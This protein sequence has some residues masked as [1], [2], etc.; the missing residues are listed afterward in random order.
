M[1]LH[2]RIIG[3]NAVSTQQ[4][5]SLIKAVTLTKEIRT[6]ELITTKVIRAIKI[7][8]VRITKGPSTQADHYYI[9]NDHQDFDTI[10]DARLDNIGYSYPRPWSDPHSSI[11]SQS[12]GT[13]FTGSR[14]QR[15]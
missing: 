11:V 3:R 9:G 5:G 12:T 14:N 7:S 4:I 1:I 15:G 8:H 2:I 10:L 13:C 6:T